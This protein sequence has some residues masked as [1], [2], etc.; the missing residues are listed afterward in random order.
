MISLL[1]YLTYFMSS[2]RSSPS[3]LKATGAKNK[4]STVF[5]FFSTQVISTTRIS[6]SI[7]ILIEIHDASIPAS[8]SW[9]NYSIPLLV[10]PLQKGSKC[11]SNSGQWVRV[12]F[13][14]RIPWRITA[15]YCRDIILWL[16]I[17]IIS[18]EFFCFWK[19]I[20]V[21]QISIWEFFQI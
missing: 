13:C 12:F 7:L 14:G 16:S 6:N 11:I 21:Q 8:C 20:L 2:T 9:N 3:Q 10:F 18:L 19:W 5:L 4:W 17:F 15:L 1:I